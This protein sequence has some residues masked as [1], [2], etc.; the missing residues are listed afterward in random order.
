MKEKKMDLDIDFIGGEISLT[1]KEELA[2]T[3]YFK[4]IKQR[5]IKI[6]KIDR[7]RVRV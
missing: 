3:K 6:I 4:N 7:K 2:L 5:K 1:K